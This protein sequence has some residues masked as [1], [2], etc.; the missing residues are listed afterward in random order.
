[1]TPRDAQVPTAA[2]EARLCRRIARG[3]RRARDEM[4]ARN[5]R[6]VYAMARRYRGLGVPFDDLVQEGT[7]GLVRAVER[8]DHRRG[9]KFST[10]AVWW[11]RRALIEAVAATRPIRMPAAAVRGLAAVRRAESELRRLPEA[12]T[13]EAV[14]ARTG[15][16][17]DRV[18]TLRGAACV[19]ASLDDRIGEDGATLGDVFADPHPVDPWRRVEQRET[20]RQVRAMVRLLPDRHREVLV[21][22]YGLHGDGAQTHAQIAASLGVGEERSRQLE[23]EGLHRLREIGVEQRWAA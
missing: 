4:I 6:L 19:T 2:E 1:M 14:A 9:W 18:E 15:L 12:A 16:S 13:P 17:V 7:V 11:I 23:R 21:R 22:R 20:C 5:Q 3:D 8:F 10:Y